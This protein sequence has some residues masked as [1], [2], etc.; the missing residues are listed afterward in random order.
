[1]GLLA[2]APLALGAVHEW[3]SFP[4]LGL[5]FLI[6]AVSS[7]RAR[8]ARRRGEH[9]P[10][11]PG[12]RLLLALHVLVVA[13]LVPLPPGL[14]KAVSPGS[15]AFYDGNSLVALQGYRP[16]SVNPADTARGLFFLAGITLV[17]ASAFRELHQD[18]WRHRLAAAI[19]AVGSVLA[20]VG[21]LQAA[22]LHP[23]RIY[24]LWRPHWDWGVFGPYV[25]RGHFAGYVVM[26]IPL[27][28]AFAAEAWQSTWERWRVGRRGW[29]ALSEPAGL[30]AVWWAALGVLLVVALVASRSR[31]GLVA[32]VVSGACL[33][34]ALRRR[35]LALVLLAATVVAVSLW[36]EVGGVVRA[37]EARGLGASRLEL[38]SEALPMARDFPVLGAGFNAFGT[39]FLRYQV[40]Y[41]YEWFGE[42]HNEYLQL[43]LDTG[44]LGAA[45]GLGLLA[46]L[47]RRCVR[48]SARGALDAGVAAAL[49]AFCVHNAADFSFQVP[50]NAATFAALAALAVR[51]GDR[52][53]E[54]WAALG[55][56]RPPLAGR[57]GR[58]VA[59]GDGQADAG[60]GRAGQ[61]ADEALVDVPPAGH[62]R[63]RRVAAVVELGR[64][65]HDVGA[66]EHGDRARPGR[67]R[68]RAGAALRGAGH[69]LGHDLG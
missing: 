64:L 10:P 46:L 55:E 4:L 28:L 35:R 24:G 6:G 30:A 36:V 23:T 51:R 37:F 63:G 45:L 56:S 29:L 39:A 52:T 17:Y 53:R 42:A 59:D 13:Q 65:H 3:A 43:L 1:V 14:L 25:S 7:W 20:L 12:W 16:I 21:L 22:S 38:W 66:A 44:A 19:L 47:A 41:R 67:G 40:R 8:S 69:H 33:P 5:S 15:F 49:L 9:S 27:A 62:Q 48:A 58:L 50:A 31:T 68:L 61:E 60:R 57:G 2:L 54:G 26:A 11:V 32:F 34:V 18:R